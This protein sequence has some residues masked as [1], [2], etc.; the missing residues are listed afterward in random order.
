MNLLKIS[1]SNL[2]DKPLTSFL[3]ILL[4]ALGIA[5]ISLL[6]LAGKQLE[7]KFTRNVAGIDMVVGAKGSP[8]QLI[9][10]SIY[11]IDAPTGNIS[12]DEANR[13]TRNP[14]VKSAI[15]LSMGDSYQ[16]YRIVGTNEKYLQHF[17]AEY[18]AGKVFSG[19]M[20]MV[21]GSK[22][23]KNLEL[24]VGD[25]FASQHGFDKEGDV[26]EEKKFKVVGILKNT[27]SVLDQLMV[28]PLESVWAVHDSHHEEEVGKGANALKLLEEDNITDEEHHHEEEAKE[29][30]SMLIKFRNPAM[31]MMMARSINQNTTL[32]TASPAIEINR[33]FALMGFGIDTLKIIALVIIIVSGLSVFVSLYNSLKE[34]KYEMALMLSMGASRTKLFFLLLLEGLIISTIGFVFGV[35]LSRLGLWLMSKN[36]EQ[37]FH[38][39]FNVLSLL[40][41]EFWLFLGALFIGLLAAAIPSLGIYKIDISRTLA[42]E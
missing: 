28:T 1:W 11:Q 17:E 26:H 10:A 23:A 13:L 15:P 4:M 42:D 3:S 12:L 41:E 40:T 39:D 14:L 30:T 6:L 2:K 19:A 37:N 38:Y 24:K 9:L 20:E 33:L 16:G 31:G 36:V 18:E 34:R 29:I 27:N 8:L 5:I 32:Q 22:V 21:V 7:E 25:T 35:V